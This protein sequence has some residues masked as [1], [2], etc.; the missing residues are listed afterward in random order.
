MVFLCSVVIQPNIPSFFS[1]SLVLASAIGVYYAY[2]DRK[3]NLID[4]YYGGKK[5][6]PVRYLNLFKQ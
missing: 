5:M 2:K 3:K 4:Y 1:V 6:S